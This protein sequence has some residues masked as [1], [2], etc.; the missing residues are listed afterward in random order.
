MFL[1]LLPRFSVS[2][3]A[4]IFLHCAVLLVFLSGCTEDKKHTSRTDPLDRAIGKN[5]DDVMKDVFSAAEEKKRAEEEQKKAGS[6]PPIPDVS[7]ILAAPKLPEVGGDKLVSLSL[8]EEVPLKDVLIELGRIADIDLEIDTGIKG[9]IILRVRDKPLNEV[10]NRI[11]IQAGLRVRQERGII[12]VERDLPYVKN[13]PV[14][15]L[16]LIRSNSGNLSISTQVLSSSGGGSGGGGGGGGG[17][18]TGASSAISSSYD[19]DMWKSIEADIKSILKHD[20]S[21]SFSEKEDDT[22]VVTTTSATGNKD[23]T[24]SLMINK[25]AGVI[26]ILANESQ[27]KN[28]AKYLER[29]RISSSAQ[30]LIEA[31]VVDVTLNDEYKTGINWTGL[32]MDPD[33][34]IAGSFASGAASNQVK[35]TVFGSDGASTSIESA[36]DL[37]EKFGV[38]RTLSSPRLTALNN[39]QAVMTFAQN[40]VYFTLKLQEQTNQSTGGASDAKLS[41]QSEF[42]TVPVGVMLTLQPSI[43]LDTN[44]ITMNVRP[45]ISIVASRV[46]DPGVSIIAQRSNLD[47]IVSQVPVIEVKE[48]DSVLKMK[49]GQVMVIGGL[50]KNSS[51]NTDTGVPFIS[52]TPLVGNLFKSVSK[53]NKVVETVIFIKA[54]IVNGGNTDATDRKVYKELMRDSHPIAF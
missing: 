13:Y 15:F 54:T 22:K 49:S 41:I 50:M 35:F 27:H 6:E 20:P 53:V 29:V 47:N 19:G 3:F 45:T 34:K 14:D 10:L 25:Q 44:E 36:V 9:G 1:A 51:D 8:T 12:R 2:A 7:T 24:S 48:L 38:S 40:E 23:E 42:K 18:T 17:V 52:R 46:D 21:L 39:Q 43:N 16:N 30:V 33:L 26:T 11:A 5:Y 28:I 37:T 31:K 32:D 4:L